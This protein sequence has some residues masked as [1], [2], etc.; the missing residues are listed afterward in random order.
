MRYNLTTPCDACPFLAGSGFTI[1]SLNAHA[2]GEFACHKACDLDEDEGIYGPSPE[3]V[4]V[5]GELEAAA[6]EIQDDLS[7]WLR[8]LAA[9]LRR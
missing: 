7:E 5:A 8:V 9:R 1:R 6:G 2:S 4:A 3:A